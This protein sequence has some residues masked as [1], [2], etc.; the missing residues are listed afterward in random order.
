[1]LLS[2]YQLPTIRNVGTV[3]VAGATCLA[4]YEGLIRPVLN[5]RRKPDKVTLAKVRAE[6]EAL[7]S[8]E[9]L[10][11]PPHAFPGARDVVTEYG[12]IKVFEWGPE[13]G[14]KV[15]L[16]HGI[17]TPCVALGVMAREF[18]RKG[19]RVMV[20]GELP[21][22]LDPGVEVSTSYTLRDIF[23]CAIHMCHVC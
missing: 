8:T 7:T 4:V 12:T 11:Y 19:C 15:L 2:T 20:F 1:M 18:V 6:A 22:E 17:G 13:D 9:A 5:P 21:L 23:I 14:E 3:L 16:V 10:P